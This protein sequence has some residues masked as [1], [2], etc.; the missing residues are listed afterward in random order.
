LTRIAI[1][2]NTRRQF[3]LISLFGILIGIA[4]SSSTS[5]F[6]LIPHFQDEGHTDQTI[7]KG[8]ADLLPWLHTHSHTSH[9][10]HVQ[11]NKLNHRAQKTSPS[12]LTQ[13]PPPR[14]P[15][16][17]SPSTPR[18]QTSST[19]SRSAENTN[20]NPRYH[21]SRVPSSLASSCKRP[22]PESSKSATGCLEPARAVTLPTLCVL[23]RG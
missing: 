18:P 10:I 13:P 20:T 3:H 14:R 5:H 9:N 17:S 4:S 6:I 21:G 23:R 2:S 7:C 22:P 15:S 11:S 19:F 12:P 8:T 1:S 16:T